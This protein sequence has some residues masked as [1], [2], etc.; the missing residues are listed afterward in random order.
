M[1]TAA[2]RGDADAWRTLYGRWLPWVWRYACSLVPDPHTAEDITSEAMTAWV[3][4]LRESGGDAPQ[5]AAWLRT[6]VR[7]KAADHHRRSGR[8]RQAMEE[9]SHWGNQESPDQ[10]DSALVAEEH[11]CDVA[12]AMAQLPE[13]Y[14]LALEWKY[15]ESLSV[16]QI[17]ERLGT[18]A[19]S[20]EAILYRARKEFR[21]TYELRQV[22]HEHRSTAS[23]DFVP[24]ETETPSGHSRS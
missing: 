20:V 17:A 13:N 6:V 22:Q 15:A 18:T 2:H 14:R 21:R 19:K 8:H 11:R 3:R 24:Q 12:N 23:K 4:R 9:V 10:A 16:N 5:V 7:N 1:I